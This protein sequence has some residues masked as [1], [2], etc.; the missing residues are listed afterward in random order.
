MLV[1][2]EEQIRLLFCLFQMPLPRSPQPEIRRARRRR[3]CYPRTHFETFGSLI[4]IESDEGPGMT[5]LV[6]LPVAAIER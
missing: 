2:D 5:V 4:H 3:A 6:N 1:K